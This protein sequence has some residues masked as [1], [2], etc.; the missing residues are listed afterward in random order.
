MFIRK[1]ATR[2]L[3]GKSYFS[4]RLVESLRT[5]DGKIQ[6]QTLIN[7]GSSYPI[8]EA[9]W[10]L[11]SDRVKNILCG[12]QLLFP[13]P[14]HIEDEAKRLANLLIKKHGKEVF[15][16][17]LKEP[18]CQSVDVN[19]IENADIKSVGAESL[20]YETAK[21]LNI[22]EILAGIGFNK[23]ETECA[24]ASIIGRLLKPGSE[25]STAHY[26][27]DKSALDEVLGTD[28]SGMH[29]NRLYE[30]SDRLFKKK[31]SIESALYQ[32]EKDLF[33]FNET[34]TLYD[35]TNT[36][37]EGQSKSNDNAA[38]G[39]SKEKRSDCALVTLA[40]VLDA[41]GFPKK[42]HIFKGNI[43]EAGTLE[44]MVSMST[45]DA[46]IVMDAGIATQENIDWLSENNYKYIVVSRKRNQTI[47]EG[48]SGV[49]VKEDK[50]NKVTSYL[51]KNEDL[52]ES[53]LY[54]HSE[55]MERKSNDFLDKFKKRFRDELQKLSDGLSKKKGS[56]KK[57]DKVCE[58]IGRL[59]EKYSKVARFYEIDI[60]A[61]EK[62]ENI[63]SIKWAYVAE[64]QSKEPGIY[65]IRTN[66]TE[67]D[68][69]QIWQT[70][71]M[72]ND[73][74]SAFRILKTD[75]GLR[76]IYHQLTDRVSGHIFITLLA[77]H[78]LHTIRCKLKA[79]G[80][81][82]SWDSIMSKLENHYRVTTSLKRENSKTLHIRKSMRANPEQL[83]IY[84]ACNIPSIPLK[85]ILTEN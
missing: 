59:K 61:D 72:L 71:R 1:I 3:K 68:N 5:H 50:D 8:P 65:C 64:K 38:L 74:E 82:D 53:E 23:K 25:L 79:Q 63:T 85:T 16:G 27:R 9:E 42:S 28:F 73:I 84:Q 32:N 20:A 81:N 36:Y 13:L 60:T 75:L 41:S 29:K 37:F 52:K 76:P 35:L 10:P 26:L 57:Y 51:V 12:A 48:V 24:L 6:Q 31:D 43:S 7:L 21:L 19:S 4:H 55:A 67:L 18:T 77:Y 34:V 47:P 46:I 40:L 22:P 17:E 33:G 15:P 11:L 69:I 58:K 78:I 2:K 14:D 44:K 45:K 39:R 54:C 49:V 83:K 80:V 62:R 70:Y 30:I 56:P 66:Q